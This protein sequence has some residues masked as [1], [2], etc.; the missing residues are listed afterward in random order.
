MKKGAKKNELQICFMGGR[1][2]GVIGALTA[3]AKD[4]NIVA[5]V[6]YSDDLKA[7]LESLD[8]AV[9]KTIR[10]KDFVRSLSDA[11]L[12]LSVHG[13]EIVKPDMLKLPRFGAVNI[14]PYLYKYKG[15]DP[16]GRAFR[17]G[18][19][20]ASIGAHIMQEQVDEGPVLVEDFVDVSGAGSVLEVY[21]KLYPYYAVVVSK[22][23]DIISDKLG[24]NGQR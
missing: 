23:L 4:N 17:D 10:D 22:A 6:S 18:E 13:R 24:R 5:A 11:D 20:K 15:A 3:L 19:F 12:L 1:Q 14:H 7:V 9:Y 16:V 2:A 21:N 8:I